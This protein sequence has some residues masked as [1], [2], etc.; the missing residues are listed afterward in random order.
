MLEHAIAT[1]DLSVRHVLVF[2]PDEW[3]YDRSAFSIRR[4]ISL[5]SGEVKFIRIHVFAGDNRLTCTANEVT[6]VFWHS[7]ALQIGLLLLL[8]LRPSVLS[9]LL[10]FY[11][12][13]INNLCSLYVDRRCCCSQSGNC[14]ERAVTQLSLMVGICRQSRTNCELSSNEA[15]TERC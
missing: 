2:C 11:I 3:R 10:G 13:T 14:C 12:M 4:T 9:L 5:V 1:A 8:L 15:T 7:G 6:E